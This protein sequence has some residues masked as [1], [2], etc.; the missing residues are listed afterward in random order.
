MQTQAVEKTK[1]E[2]ISI[3]LDHDI[4]QRIEQAA[5]MDHR[6]ITSFIIASAVASADEILKR[7][8]QMV[9]SAGDWD[10]F[11]DAL[12]NPPAPNAALKSAFAIY[13]EMD[14]RSDV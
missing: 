5:A 1:S 10:L 4:K 3:R 2:R 11:Y 8:D 12:S 14:I 6:S 13:K 7:S 9:L